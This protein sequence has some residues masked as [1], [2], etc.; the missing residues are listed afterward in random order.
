M[1]LWEQNPD[2][3][4]GRKHIPILLE[5][6]AVAGKTNS[7]PSSSSPQHHHHPPLTHPLCVWMKE[8]AAVNGRAVRARSTQ[9]NKPSFFLKLC[10]LTHILKQPAPPVL[11]VLG[12]ATG[13]PTNA[14]TDHLQPER[15]REA[16]L[17]TFLSK[18]W[19]NHLHCRGISIK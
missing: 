19:E 9:P 3:S 5:L 18:I 17:P 13:R 6:F 7:G 16:L 12:S 11:L 15:R 2:S 14:Q 1:R 8:R 4:G 10:A